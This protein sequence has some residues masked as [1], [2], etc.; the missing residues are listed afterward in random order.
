MRELQADNLNEQRT[1]PGKAGLVLIIGSLSAFGPFSI[2]MYLPGLPSLSQDLG[3]PAWQV[4]LTLT[5]CLVGLAFGQIIAGPISD[6]L[7]RR[8]PLLVGL[9][10]YAA[11]SLLCALAPSTPV[12]ILFRLV[13]GA[14]GAA[15]IVLSRAIVRDLFAGDEIA[16]FFG[17]TSMISGVAP[18]LAPVVGGQVLSFTSW[19]GVFIVLMVFGALLLATIFFF[20]GESLP[21]QRR[22]S[23]G[24]GKTLAAFKLLLTD[25]HFVGYTVS[26]GLASAAMFSYI[27]G[28]PFVVEDIYHVSP[29]VYSLIFAINA[30]GIITTSQISARLVGRVPA[31]TLMRLGLSVSMTGSL[32][33]IVAVAT[34]VGLAG[35]L[36]CFFLVVASI[37][38][39]MP[40]SIALAMADHPEIAGSASGLMGVS[41]F[42]IGGIVSPLVGIGGTTSA[43][44]LAIVMAVVSTGGFLTFVLLTGYQ[45][46]SRIVES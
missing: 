21:P 22:Q 9:L 31:R 23:G 40:N 39:I 29:Q 11:S 17:L 4:Q 18:I 26:A 16:R 5:A 20:L 14:S 30:V 34:N 24:L 32:L 6:T 44:P 41:Q 1:R 45:G 35:I 15:G 25:R 46:K 36:P 33:L 43:W 10:L 27:S 37:G 7:G 38:F 28:S 3:G 8:R 19:R 13:Q 42:L 2:D 12:L